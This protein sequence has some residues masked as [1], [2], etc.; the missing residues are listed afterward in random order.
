MVTTLTLLVAVLALMVSAAALAI[1]W[2]QLRLQ[3]DAAG[4]RGLIFKVEKEQVGLIGATNVTGTERYRVTVK[5]L[6]NVRDEVSLHL[7]RDEHPRD[8]AVPSI[9]ERTLMREQLS[10]NDGQ[11][12]RNFDLE[13]DSAQGLWCVLSWVEPY[14]DGIRTCAFRRPLGDVSL[15]EEWRWVRFLRAR[16]RI[17][18][19]GHRQP[20]ALIRL[21]VGT[22]RKLGCWRLYRLRDLEPG[23]GPIESDVNEAVVPQAQPEASP[24]SRTTLPFKT[25]MP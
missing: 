13:K 9:V 23:Q 18:S 7:V 25:D 21:V 12:V 5:F 1:A 10:W 24:M 22:P 20:W 19:W 15:L 2:S 4:G 16:R 6:G 8:P 3:R 11:D 17:E 14:G